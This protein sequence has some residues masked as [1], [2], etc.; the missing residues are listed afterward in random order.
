MRALWW[1]GEGRAHAGEALH[2]EELAVGVDDEA[3]GRPLVDHAPALPGVVLRG[4][5]EGAERR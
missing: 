1:L 2:A 4:G 3:C 5:D